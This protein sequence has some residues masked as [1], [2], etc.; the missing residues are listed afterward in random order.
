MYVFSRDFLG[1]SWRG[2]GDLGSGLRGFS[3]RAGT[4]PGGNDVLTERD[5]GL[6]FSA[7]T[8]FPPNTLPEGKMIYITVGAT[9][10]A[11]TLVDFRSLFF[12][13]PYFLDTYI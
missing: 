10:A 7:F 2:F 4:T 13:S 11:G 8:T 12:Y 1:A 3:W 6:T 5:L 9:D